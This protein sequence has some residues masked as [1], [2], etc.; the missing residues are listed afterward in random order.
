L[1]HIE[2]IYNADFFESSS[3]AAEK[4]EVFK[5]IH[6]EWEW[7]DGWVNFSA[8]RRFYLRRVVVFILK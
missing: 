7:L 6:Q 8:V 3:K 1:W 5:K 4:S 2:T